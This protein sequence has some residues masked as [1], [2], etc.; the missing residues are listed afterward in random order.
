MQ[1]ETRFLGGLVENVRLEKRLDGSEEVKKIAGGRLF[2]VEC[3]VGAK[4]FVKVALYMFWIIEDP[5]LLNHTVQLSLHSYLH[6]PRSSVTV[7]VLVLFPHFLGL[8][9]LP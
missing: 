1:Y 2:P 7:C 3:M 8:P 6:S 9:D 4:P 5:V